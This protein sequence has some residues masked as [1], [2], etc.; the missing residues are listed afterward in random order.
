MDMHCSD[1]ICF[2]VLFQP[3]MMSVS[4]Y[5]RF[6]TVSQSGGFERLLESCNITQ[7]VSKQPLA[8]GMAGYSHS[9]SPSAGRPLH[10]A[11]RS[12]SE[13][14]TRRRQGFVAIRLCERQTAPWGYTTAQE[15]HKIC[16]YGYKTM[17]VVVRMH[18]MPR[19]AFVQTRL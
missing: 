4:L 14:S 2:Y 9:P 8:L 12:R 13:Q 1:L 18:H 19:V 11:R 17:Q 7:G 16:A 10:A 3:V 15:H 6:Q 5:Y